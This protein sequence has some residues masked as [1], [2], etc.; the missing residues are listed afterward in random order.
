MMFNKTK[1]WKKFRNFNDYFGCTAHYCK[2]DDDTEKSE[3]YFY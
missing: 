1:Y 2:Q 3:T